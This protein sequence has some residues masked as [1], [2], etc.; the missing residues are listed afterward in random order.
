[1][2]PKSA[3]TM[4]SGQAIVTLSGK[5]HLLG[6]FGSQESQIAYDQLIVE[7]LAN[8]RRSFRPGLGWQAAREHCRAAAAG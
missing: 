5:N 3:A 2:E 8:S 4:Q 6:S 1:M 7:S